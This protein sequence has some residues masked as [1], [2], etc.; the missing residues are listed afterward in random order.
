VLLSVLVLLLVC[1][2]SSPARAQAP[3]CDPTGATVVAPLPAPPS[4]DGEID[5][6]DCLRGVDRAE[7][8]MPGVPAPSQAQIHLAY[9][10]WAVVPL[11]LSGAWK[12]SAYLNFDAPVL[13]VKRK[14]YEGDVFR[15]PRNA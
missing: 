14:A 3:M 10:D 12:V 2:A 13:P 7:R 15:P 9:D 1:V 4:D 8:C 6:L 5:W 11:R